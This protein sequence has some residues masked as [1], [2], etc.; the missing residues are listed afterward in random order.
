MLHRLRTNRSILMAAAWFLL[1][2][3]LFTWPIVLHMADS[4]AGQFGDNMQ[5]VWLI[6]WFQKSMFQLHQLPFQVPQLNYP[7]GW[8]LARTEIVPFEILLALP[9]SLLAGPVLGYNLVIVVSFFLSGMAAFFWVRHLTGNSW[10]AVISGTLFGFVPFHV[11]HF[12]AGHLNVAST[13]WFPPYF[14]GLFLLLSKPDP[15]RFAAPLT[16]ISLGLISMTSQYTFYMT[17]VI[18]LFVSG[19]YLLIFDRGRIRDLAFWKRAASA[20]IW[21][22]P[23]VA[24]G[25][26]PFLALAAGNKLPNR[27]VADVV[28]GSASVSDFLLPSTDHFLWGKW[29]AENFARDHWIEGTLYIGVP[30]MVL[31]VLGIGYG[32]KS[33][34]FRNFTI[35]ALLLLVVAFVLSL[36]THL[37]WN[38]SMVHLSIPSGLQSFLGR[39][40]T[41]IPLPGYLM[42]RYFPFYAK[43]RTFKRTGIFVLLATS[44]LAGVGTSELIRRN[45]GRITVPLAL[46]ILALI[47]LDF[48]PGPLASMVKVQPRPVDT[49]LAAQPGDGAV[50]VFPF[51]LEQDQIQVY[52]SLVN[53]KPFLGGFFNAY[54]P[55]QYL[56]IKPVMDAF[57]DEASVDILRQLGVK[58]VILERSSYPSG[59]MFEAE[60]ARLGLEPAGQFGAQDLYM[61]DQNPQTPGR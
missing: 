1:L 29:V 53:H 57:P 7:Q 2:S 15:S 27:T 20:V 51:K 52:Y 4:V 42:F 35:L 36:G 55:G 3:V 38:E 50:A 41:S 56:R 26:Y 59:W 12:L 54:P 48:Y 9:A 25:E 23:L 32:L 46:A 17:V 61:V 45:G 31:T 33:E 8:D 21:S 30:G 11:A 22:A 19:G 24:I 6:G 16:G 28:N 14:M 47:F 34:S 60:L 40:E 37:F 18:T 13:M 10:A 49:W 43:M 5:F 39:K 58:Y 44:A